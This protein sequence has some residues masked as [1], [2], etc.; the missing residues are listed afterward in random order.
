MHRKTE[1]GIRNEYAALIQQTSKP[2][3]GVYVSVDIDINH[4]YNP[5]YDYEITVQSDSV[6]DEER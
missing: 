5:E 4:F 2:D 1:Y 6:L 3:D